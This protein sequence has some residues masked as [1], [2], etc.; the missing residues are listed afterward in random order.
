MLVFWEAVRT[1]SDSLKCGR[2]DEGVDGQHTIQP[3]KHEAEQNT[4]LREN[5]RKLLPRILGIY[6]YM[7]SQCCVTL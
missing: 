4:M 2:R 7:P 5:L 3:R 6:I 1:I